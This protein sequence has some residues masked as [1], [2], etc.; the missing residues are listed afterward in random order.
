MNNN[1]NVDALSSISTN[2]QPEIHIYLS[3]GPSA[4]LSQKVHSPTKRRGVRKETKKE[5]RERLCDE[6][7]ASRI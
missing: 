6:A 5:G 1:K 2:T 4:C 7:L 3:P